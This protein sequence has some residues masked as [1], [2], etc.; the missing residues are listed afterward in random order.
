MKATALAAHTAL[1]EPNATKEEKEYQISMLGALHERNA[2]RIDEM[3]SRVQKAAIQNEN[4]F[5]ELMNACK[6]CSLGQITGALYRVDLQGYRAPRAPV[7]DALRGHNRRLHP[8]A[9]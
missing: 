1:M 2:D 6:V 5:E 4:M 7:I 3:L 8:I 9:D